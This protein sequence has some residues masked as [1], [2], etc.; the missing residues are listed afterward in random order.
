MIIQQGLYV[1]IDGNWG[2]AQGLLIIDDSKWEQS[3]YT[4]IDEAS[5]HN[6]C[7]VAE[8]VDR[9]IDAGR[10]GDFNTWLENLCGFCNKAEAYDNDLCKSCYEDSV[11]EVV[12][13]E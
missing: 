12:T 7:D 13:A 5:D 6:K 8:A 3:D 1:A 4:M 2:D 10:P 11:E 9:W